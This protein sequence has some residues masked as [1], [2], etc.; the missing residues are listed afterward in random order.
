[1]RNEFLNRDAFTTPH[2][3]TAVSGI[4][5]RHPNQFNQ[6]FLGPLLIRPTLQVDQQTG[7]GHTTNG[8]NRRHPSI[9]G[10]SPVQYEANWFK[11]N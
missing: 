3:R 5:F 6:S 9:S 4:A 10:L 11:R 2:D 8:Q 7:A 1:M